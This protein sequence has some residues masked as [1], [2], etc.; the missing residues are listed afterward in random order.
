M[1]RKTK[2]DKKELLTAKLNRWWDEDSAN[3]KRQDWLWFMYDLWKEGHHYARYEKATQQILTTP[4]EDGRPKV[5]VNKIDASVRAVV[6][7]ALRNRPKAE[8]TPA[9]GSRD[10]ID[11]VV[12]Q[13]LFLDY[14]HDRLDLRTIER[15][16]V[17]ESVTSGIAWVQ[18][19]WD[20]S[21]NDGQGEI[22]VNEIDKYD[23][24]WSARARDPREARRFCLAVSRPIELLKTDPKYKDADWDSVKPDNQRSSSTL[25]ERLMTLESGA[26]QSGGKNDQGSVLLKEFWYYGDPELD[27]DPDVIYVCALAGGVIVRPSEPT[28]LTRMPFFRLCT[29]KKKLSMVGKSWVKN[30]IPLNKRLNHL[31]SSLAEYNTIMNKGFWIADKGAGVKQLKNEH[32]IIYEK[33]KGFDLSQGNVTS[34][35]PV[36]MQELQYLLQMFEDISAVHDATMGRIPTGAKSGKALEALQVGDSNNLSEIV[37][38]TEIW[39]EELYEYL[40]TLAAQK[41]QFA[42]D[43]TPVT[44]TGQREFLTVIG[45]DAENQ[46]DEAL[47]IKKRN[48]VDVKITSYLAH[49][50]EARREAIAELASLIPDLD[51]Q[52]ILEVYEVG[53]IADIIKRINEARAAR[54]EQELQMAQAQQQMQIQGQAQSS[55]IQMAQQQ[56]SQPQGAGAQEAIAAIRM[57]LQGQAPDLPQQVTPEFIS[58]FDQF[59]ASPEAQQLDPGMVRILQAVRDQLATG[60][61]QAGQPSQNQP[62]RTA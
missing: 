61:Q 56:A 26:E 36:L 10:G 14:L 54:Q 16:A 32:G 30:L 60:G 43:I 27:E 3:R 45:E 1:A 46:P 40:L 12:K 47:V 44:Q 38:N 57:I 17:E 31:F 51:P 18:V 2:Q 42:R 9:D 23:L 41:Y 15:G 48:I 20:E 21:E 53:P 11:A 39:L 19:L 49:T 59:L 33:K 7:Y 55:A 24:Y 35:S 52:T 8:V 22:V 5:M 13:N 6:N 37:E 34:L 4:R 62:V 28:D 25:K 29:S 58:Y 50:A